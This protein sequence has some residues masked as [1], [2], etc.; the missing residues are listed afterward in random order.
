MVFKLFDCNSLSE[1]HFILYCSTNTCVEHS[2]A[3]GDAPLP[4]PP[5]PK[6]HQMK[7]GLT[8][9]SAQWYFL[10]YSVLSH[11]KGAGMTSLVDFVTHERIVSFRVKNIALHY[12]P[13]TS[14][15]FLYLISC[16][17]IWPPCRVFVCL[18]FPLP[19]VIFSVSSHDCMPHIL[20]FLLR[21]SLEISSYN[22][23]TLGN[24]PSLLSWPAFLCHSAYHLPCTSFV[25]CLP[26]QLEYQLHKSRDCFVC[27]CIP[28]SQRGF[29]KSC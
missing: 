26:S 7:F 17:Y 14:S 3:L 9:G 12:P 13:P 11:F 24:S 6:F 22:H 16:L 25:Y 27:W 2:H 15:H 10:F 1:A 23:P 4:L 18:L 19:G 28:A 5:S 21:C 29:Q 20:R 8:T